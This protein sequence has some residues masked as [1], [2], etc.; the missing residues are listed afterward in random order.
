MSAEEML[1]E[2][3]YNESRKNGEYF[4]NQVRG[5]SVHLKNRKFMEM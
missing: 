1:K 5:Y 3:K 2:G 4:G